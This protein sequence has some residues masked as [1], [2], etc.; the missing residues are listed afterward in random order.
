MRAASTPTTYYVHQQEKPQP[1][2]L[3][4][5]PLRDP[6][7]MGM[8]MEQPVFAPQELERFADQARVLNHQGDGDTAGFYLR[9]PDRR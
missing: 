1:K 3:R 9:R 8:C 6:R 7:S 4:D 2:T 5:V